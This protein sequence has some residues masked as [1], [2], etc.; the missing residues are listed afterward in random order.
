LDT[1]GRREG[2]VAHDSAFALPGYEPPGA[3][4]GPLSSGF[5]AAED[6]RVDIGARDDVISVVVDTAALRSPIV[7]ALSSKGFV[8]A[9]PSLVPEAALVIAEASAD[10]DAQLA[11]LRRRARPDSAI[12][13]VLGT[14]SGEAVAKAHKAGAFACLRAPL[15]QE[16]L[17]GFV[18]SAH[19]SRAARVQAADLARKLDLEAHLAS[20]GRISAG[21]SHEVSSPLA[22]ATLNMDTVARE[23]RRM[24]EALKWLA[25]SPEEEL[26]QRLGVVRDRIGSFESADGLAGAIEDTVAA[27]ERLRTLFGTMR[28]L[29]GR[30]REVRRE[31]IELLPLVAEV[32][33]WLT[34]ELRGIEVEVIGEPLVAVADRTLLG[35]LL[36]N[37]TS[38]AAYAAKSLSAP[39]IRLH[40]YSGG[41]RVIVS[42]RD[43]GPGIPAELQE[44]I[45]EPFFTTRRGNGGTGLGLALCREYALQMR[46]E[47]SVWS[48][49]GRGACFRV[50]LP[51][52]TSL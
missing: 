26:A 15:V 47:L 8:V 42:V 29:V 19:D 12:L 45:F 39:R 46:A 16:E 38:N 27:H 14:P 13:M 48:L 20:I 18:T 17:L 6:S 43:N 3:P 36:H 5:H 21:L 22:A 49:P 44:R 4:R 23:C 2:G 32:R 35:Q 33:K 9:G 24:V 25:F 51:H 28:D 11:D 37:L 34:Q 52:R 10:I 50:S 31:P 41:S 30:T 1:R 7:A 40:V